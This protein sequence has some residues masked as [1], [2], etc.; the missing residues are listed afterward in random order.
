MRLGQLVGWL[1]FFVFFGAMVN[2]S[3]KENAGAENLTPY[4]VQPGD[5]L[6]I[7]VWKE[8]QLQKEVMVRPDGFL[9]FPLAGEVMVQGKSFTQI[10]KMLTERLNAFIPDSVVTVSSKQLL[11]NKIF[12]VGKVNRPG[13]YPLVRV[14]DV[15]QAL[16]IAGGLSSFADPSEI[17]ILRRDARG[18]QQALLF[19][20]GDIEDGNDLK[21]NIL[22]QSGDS[23][24]VP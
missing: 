9:S 17:K 20:Y 15:T 13:E 22:L 6:D 7:M 16:A 19:R 14:T 5:V 11:S 1:G 18:V 23:V 3:A 4:L 2:V 8:E 24:V 12:V 21:Q 10:Q